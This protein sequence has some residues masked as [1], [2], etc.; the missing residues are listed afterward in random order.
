MSVFNKFVGSA[1]SKYW[2]T[3]NMNAASRL[4]SAGW[5]HA[6]IRGGAS[7]L[8]RWAFGGTPGQTATRVGSMLAGAYLGRQA[9]HGIGWAGGSLISMQAKVARTPFNMMQKGDQ[10]GLF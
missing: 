3:L 4:T 9:L 2:K 7:G 8:G 6:G 5:R 1:A 10:P